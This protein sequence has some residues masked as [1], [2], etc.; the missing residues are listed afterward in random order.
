[1]N[2]EV[3]L[4]IKIIKEKK[5]LLILD[6]GIGI[7]LISAKKYLSEIGNSIKN[8]KEIQNLLKNENVTLISK[9]G[10]GI[11]SV[12]LICSKMVIISKKPDSQAYRFS[13]E[14]NS[15]FWKVEKIERN[16]IGTEIELELIPEFANLDIFEWVDRYFLYSNIDIK[17][18]E[19]ERSKSISS[20]I[21]IKSLQEYITNINEFQHSRPYLK[22]LFT[23]QE[24]KMNIYFFKSSREFDYLIFNKGIYVELV[25]DNF[26]KKI[27]DYLFIIIDLKDNVINL[28]VTREEIVRNQKWNEI[29]LEIFEKFLAKI[30]IGFETDI[31]AK[32]E[33]L[34]NL[35]RTSNYEIK[36]SSYLKDINVLEKKFFEKFF[37]N[38]KFPVIQNDKLTSSS[39]FELSDN[40][41]LYQVSSEKLQK[42]I[43]LVNSLK[44]DYDEILINPIKLSFFI[45]NE[46]Y[47]HK[48]DYYLKK[49]NINF[50]E[51]ID[52][53]KLLIKQIDETFTPLTIEF[54]PENIKFVRYL[55]FTR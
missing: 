20:E 19:D 38:I 22:Y 18:H 24:D 50:E 3:N 8:D 26:H 27:F 54:I 7:D 15:H 32:F 4:G 33:F 40:K 13:I 41:V 10:L 17:V 44:A 2:P 12:F 14:K 1:M 46:K 35:I 31:I 49:L 42:E 34:S 6:N 39:I 51:K 30:E 43:D 25:R 11:L 29:Q 21:D 48:F 9:F 45:E 16:V 28:K 47:I 5:K 52:F 55:K 53:R 36:M 23:I 37:N